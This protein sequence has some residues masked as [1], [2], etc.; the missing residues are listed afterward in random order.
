M[1]DI[2]SLFLNR[3]FTKYYIT[4]PAMF[5]TT[6]RILVYADIRR[7]AHGFFRFANQTAG[8]DPIERPNISIFLGFHLRCSVT[9]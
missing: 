4:L 6:D 8:P 5:L 1:F 3:S 9:N 7:S 2:R